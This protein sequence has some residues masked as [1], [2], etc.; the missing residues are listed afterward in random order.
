MTSA[1]KPVSRTTSDGVY[2]SG[3]ESCALA[4]VQEPA[5][6]GG[7]FLDLYAEMDDQARMFVGR[8]TVTAAAVSPGTISRSRVV[9]MVTVPGARAFYVETIPPSPHPAKQLLVGLYI[10]T[11]TAVGPITVAP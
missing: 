9:A 8:F 10:S 3:G 4:I 2:S 1:L 5:D 7:W 6:P 11:M